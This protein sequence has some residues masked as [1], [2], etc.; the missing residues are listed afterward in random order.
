MKI[1]QRI[2][3]APYRPGIEKPTELAVPKE[4]ADP[5]YACPPEHDLLRMQVELDIETIQLGKDKEED[6]HNGD[7]PAQPEELFPVL[8]QYPFDDES[9][10]DRHPYERA[11]FHDRAG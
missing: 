9:G 4:P 3:A 11:F 1:E 6:K 2:S 8:R 5:R 7:P 10:A